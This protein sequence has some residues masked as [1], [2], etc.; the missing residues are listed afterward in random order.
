MSQAGIIEFESAH[1]EIPTSFVTNSG[2]AIPIANTLEILGTTVANHGI[3]LETTGSGN[4]VTAVAQYA[5]ATGATTTTAAGFASFN[6]TE[7]SVD[8]NGFVSANNGH[9]VIELTGNSGTATPDSSGNIN[10]ITANTTFGFVG[11]GHTL[12]MDVT[13][14]NPGF[15]NLGIGSSFP[16]I[17]AGGQTNSGYGSAALNGIVGG[18]HNTGIGGGALQV[19]TNGNYNTMVGSQS[20]LVLAGTASANCA[21]GYESLAS[22]VSGSFNCAFGYESLLDCLGSNNIAIGSVA[23][24]NYTGT[25]SSNV[26]LNH[27]GVLGESN[28]MRLGTAGSQTSSYVSGITGVTVAASSP[29]G[30]NS[31]GQLSDLGFGTVGQVFTSGGAGVSPSWANGAS[32]LSIKSVTHGASPY[33]VLADDEFLACQTSGGV[34]TILLPNAPTTGRVITIK[35]SNGAAAASNISVT[36]VGGTVTIDGQTTYTMSSNYQSIDVIFDGSNYEVF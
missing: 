17:T 33:T 16:N 25:E 4:T 26:L 27:A 6:N 19:L 2:T 20:G 36:T 5:A 15:S 13:Q 29:V 9:F 11:S 12:T 8:A 23:G 34:I 31:S 35:D 14:P 1:P 28:V 24:G 3:P 7:F 18:R 32:T 22:S 10:I 21:Y 30:V